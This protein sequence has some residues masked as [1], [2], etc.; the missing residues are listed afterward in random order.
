M[1]LLFP[2]SNLSYRFSSMWVNFKSL[3]FLYAAFLT[4]GKITET[5]VPDVWSRSGNAHNPTEQATSFLSSVNLF[6]FYTSNSNWFCWKLFWKR[7]F[8]WFIHRRCRRVFQTL[9]SP[10]HH[11]NKKEELN[12][13]RNVQRIIH[14][15]KYRWLSQNDGKRDELFINDE[16]FDWKVDFA[17]MAF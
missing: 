14:Y 2:L 5:Y 4:G 15:T 8:S 11:L 12:G 9:F 17:Q 1:L 3:N 6:S 7:S 10:N 13:C 16:A